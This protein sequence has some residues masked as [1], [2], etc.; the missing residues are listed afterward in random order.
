MIRTIVTKAKKKK[1]GWPVI[2]A[3]FYRSGTSLVRRIVDSHSAFHCPPE[4][5]FFR[6]FYGDYPVD[7]IAHLRFFRTARSFGLSEDELFKICG[8]A[9]VACHE[10]AAKK[11]G[12]RRWA[13]KNPENLL[14][15]NQWYDLLKGNLYVIFIHRNPLD[16]IASLIEAD[17]PKTVPRQ[18]EQKVDMYCDYVRRGLNFREKHS[19][20]S[21]TMK[22]EDLVESPR[23]VLTGLFNFVGEEFEENVLTEFCSSARQGGIEDPKAG[24]EKTIHR[25]SVNR[26]EKDLSEEQVAFIG[27]RCEEIMVSMKYHMPKK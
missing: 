10:E 7:D 19:D 26:W 9:F 25:H 17:F 6:D 22:Y 21:F 15:L 11:F 20:I 16:T 24:M 23:D 1:S 8:G 18:F 14:Y 27:K 2:I 13:D 4:I 5:K 12:K 3:G